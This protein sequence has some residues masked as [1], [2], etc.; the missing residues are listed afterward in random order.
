MSQSMKGTGIT[1]HLDD[2]G[3]IVLPVELRRRMNLEEGTPLEIF[4]QGDQ[5]ILQ[6]HMEACVFCGNRKE[7]APFRGKWICKNCREEVASEA[8]Q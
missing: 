5:I 6:K 8:E 4:A 2:M 1:R 7:L 3:R